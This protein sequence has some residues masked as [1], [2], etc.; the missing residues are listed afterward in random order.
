MDKVCNSL[1][2]NLI[3]VLIAWS[4]EHALEELGHFHIIV[5]NQASVYS[6]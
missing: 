3:Q 1:K 5:C 4:E 2:F 6:T